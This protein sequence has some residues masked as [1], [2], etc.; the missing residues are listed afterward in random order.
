MIFSEAIE[1]YFFVSYPFSK[2]LQIHGMYA[3]KLL[4]NLNLNVLQ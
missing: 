4:K 2:V 3:T 1:L